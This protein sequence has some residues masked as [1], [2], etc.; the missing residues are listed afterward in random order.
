MASARSCQQP[1]G[2]A[3]SQLPILE[4]KKHALGNHMEGK[5]KS[6]ALIGESRRAQQSKEGERKGSRTR[7]AERAATSGEE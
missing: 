6:P 2:M 5:K 3:I 7:D 4:L 1:K